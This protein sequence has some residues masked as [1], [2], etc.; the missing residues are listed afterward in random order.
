VSIK[1][2]VGVFENRVLRGI[3]APKRDE[4]LIGDCGKLNEYPSPDIIRM[5]THRPR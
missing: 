2:R 5:N 4:I 1:Y 3:F